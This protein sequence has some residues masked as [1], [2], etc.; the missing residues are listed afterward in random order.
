MTMMR[1]DDLPR[2]E[3]WLL[4][5]TA[6]VATLGV[7]LVYFGLLWASGRVDAALQPPRR[8]SYRERV[9]PGLRRRT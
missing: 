7:A 8:L 1:D 5:V 9:R 2:W 4:A 3:W 6:F